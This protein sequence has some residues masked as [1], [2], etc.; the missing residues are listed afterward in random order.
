MRLGLAGLVALVACHTDARFDVLAMTEHP[1]TAAARVEVTTLSNGLR[2]A[3]L[4]D[5][6]ARITSID[7]H[8]DVGAS[9]DSGTRPGLALYLAHVLAELPPG[10]AAM[11]ARLAV[12][13]DRT[14][15]TTTAL[16]VEGALDRDARRLEATC[17]DFTP[18]RLAIARDEALLQLT[19]TPSSF[20]AAVWGAGHPYAHVLG[21]PALAGATADELC[22]FFKAHYGPA[23]ATL[24]VTGA[25]DAD[26][27]A[28]IRARFESIP[29]GT[30]VARAPVP[31]IAPAKKRQ[32][33]VVFGLAR[34][35][36]AV[37][38]SV[39]APGDRDDLTAELA[40]R[41]IATWD[42]K[43]HV[44]L[45]GGVRGRAIVI[46]READRENQLGDAHDKLHDLLAEAYQL[47]LGNAPEI[48]ADELLEATQD[49]DDV[50]RRGER[51]A[52]L[53]S[54]G[55][56]PDLIR[57]VQVLA[58]PPKVRQWIRDHLTEG[59]GRTL[60]LIPAGPG[61]LPIEALA[62][63]ASS[64]TEVLFDATGELP[65]V[66]PMRRAT[67]DYTLENGLRVVLAPDSD[68]ITV[69]V[70]LVLP[71][72]KA[73]EPAPGLALRAAAEL[74]SD[75]GYDAGPDAQ[76]RLVWYA[77]H[78]GHTDA[79][80]TR[81]TTQLRIVGL[82]TLADWHVFELGWHV[83]TGHYK[84]FSAV[85]D[86][87]WHRYGPRVAT[88]IASGRFDPIVIRARVATWF[89]GWRPQ[90]VAAA[91]HVAP[92]AP[93]RPEVTETAGAEVVDLWIA[94]EASEVDRAAARLLA[95]VVRNRLAAT[96]RTSATIAVE[97]DPRDRRLTLAAQIDPSAAAQTAA[98]IGAEL[99]QLRVTPPSTDELDRARR[100]ALSA[101][102]AAEIGPSGR[103]RQLEA[104]I[105]ANEPLTAPDHDLDALRTLT[106]DDV[107]TAATLLLDPARATIDL[108]GPPNI[109]TPILAALHAKR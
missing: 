107:R 24:V 76:H 11:T 33:A 54:T 20:V 48:G 73:D 31:A 3:L 71:I 34:P 104:A 97:L 89:G 84:D 85:L 27:M 46:A 38:F 39:P 70:R 88:W 52:E 41:W 72:G 65:P 13:L 100:H 58:A 30:V 16:D 35:T 14:E 99:D 60:D 90:P 12:D 29:R 83:T 5:P 44:M 22:A 18:E 32:R 74:E 75:D 81:T 55:H 103:G 61:G 7:L 10:G 66:P 50:E 28:K 37:A 87:I 36:A 77:H 59:S 19:G 94:Y 49:V 9:D 26:L 96:T 69:D 15:L 92:T 4:R 67:T 6:R 17:A 56:A 78:A 21:D 42:D 45:V 93:P 47:G 43:V 63:P 2:V 108:H 25:L 98:Q 68:A 106:P 86:Q 105:L 82:A 62:D 102:L 23:A 40:A 8:Y 53:V 101:A 79:D 64:T 51:I 57:R 1:I 95:S 109:S 91:P 80:V